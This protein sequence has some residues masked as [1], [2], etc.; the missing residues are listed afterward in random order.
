MFFICLPCLVLQ[1]V[2]LNH[3]SPRTRDRR[4]QICLS[5]FIPHL[6]LITCASAVAD[7]LPLTPPPARLPSPPL[8]LLL[9]Q[10]SASLSASPQ[11]Q[12]RAMLM[13]AG[14]WSPP[15]SGSETPLS[16]ELNG[17]LP[18]SLGQDSSP[19]MIP[20]SGQENMKHPY[21]PYGHHYK[22]HPHHM[23]HPADPMANQLHP[24]HQVSH[25]VTSICNRLTHANLSIS[26]KHTA[27]CR[28]CIPWPYIKAMRSS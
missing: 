5:T 27:T 28:R 18:G 13:V 24:H 7:R 10:P 11:T 9:L 14:I 3:I 4:S 26:S 21:V 2:T 8:L 12:Q 16:P 17:S 25:A 22:H 6:T 23:P 19:E 1:K 20:H 15:D